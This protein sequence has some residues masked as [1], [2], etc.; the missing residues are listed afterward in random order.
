MHRMTKLNQR[1]TN[2]GGRPA[3]SRR[4][5][6]LIAYADADTRALYRDWLAS[7]GCD[8]V[9]TSDGHDALG[10]VLRHQPLR[11]EPRGSLTYRV[12]RWLWSRLRV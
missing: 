10:Q 1:A 8:V 7:A 12:G 11:K 4:P 5:S 3:P 6:I 2:A 9:E